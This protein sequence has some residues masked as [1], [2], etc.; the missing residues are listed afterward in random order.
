MRLLVATRSGPKLR[1]I[2]AILRGVPGLQIVDLNDAGIPPSPEEDGIEKFQTF[3]EN[4]IAK[5]RYFHERSG[6][7]TVADDSGICV[8]ALDGAPGVRS[9][10]FAPG[11]AALAPEDV[12]RA[13][14]EQLL[15]LLGDLDLARRTAHYA[16]VAALV[17]KGAP[18]VAFEGRADG[19]ILGHPRGKG[20]F[21][22]DPLF[23][24]P[25][26][27]LTFAE[28]TPAEKDARSHRGAA[29]RA[30]AEFLREEGR[31]EG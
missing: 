10:R 31:G 28:L 21:G 9:R 23:F 30:L 22:Y 24:D 13:N 8:D 6:L 26:S 3:E 7:P 16:C 18:P 27:G 4:A 25:P 29:F 19:L 1:E 20:G 15:R 5:A 14:N 17:R 12:D 11:T 2:R